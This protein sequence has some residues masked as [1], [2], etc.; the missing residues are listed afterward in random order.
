MSTKQLAPLNFSVE[1]HLGRGPLAGL[2]IV[3]GVGAGPQGAVAGVGEAV[4]YRA[5]TGR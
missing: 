4:A 1:A 2:G 3:G 5:V